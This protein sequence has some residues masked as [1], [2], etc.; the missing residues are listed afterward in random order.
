M[1]GV[2]RRG[3]ILAEVMCLLL[4]VTTLAHIIGAFHHQFIGQIQDMEAQL[5][6]AKAAYFQVAG[7]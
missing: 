6:A 1:S 4:L 3:F 2:K 7:S 5:V